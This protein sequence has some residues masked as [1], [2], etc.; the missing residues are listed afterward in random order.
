V[1]VSGDLKVEG[2]VYVDSG[3]LFVASTEFLK[4]HLNLPS[5]N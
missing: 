1:K 4:V 3:K 2:K 5:F